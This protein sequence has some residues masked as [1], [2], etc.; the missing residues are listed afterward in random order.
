MKNKKGVKM[1][2][3]NI[4][5]RK[6]NKNFDVKNPL[7]KAEDVCHICVMEPLMEIGKK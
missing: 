6:H 4:E 1:F 2:L 3:Y 5:C 7:T